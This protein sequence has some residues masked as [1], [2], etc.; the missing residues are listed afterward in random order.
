MRSP[1]YRYGYRRNRLPRNADPRRIALGGGI[2]ILLFALFLA[3]LF[4]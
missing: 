3:A 2:A 4:S 1:W